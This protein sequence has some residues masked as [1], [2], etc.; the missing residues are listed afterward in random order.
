ML[1]FKLFTA[2]LIDFNKQ[3]QI[4]CKKT[5]T[6][7][8]KEM[9]NESNAE[10]LID[11]L[12]CKYFNEDD[13]RMPSTDQSIDHLQNFVF[14]FKK[15]KFNLKESLLDINKIRLLN[16]NNE[17]DLPKSRAFFI[18]NYPQIFHFQD[19]HR[20]LKCKQNQSSFSL[21]R[22]S[23]FERSSS[24]D[25][26]KSEQSFFNSSNQETS[27]DSS[28]IGSESA[29]EQNKSFDEME[30]SIQYIM[31]I[32]FWEL[33]D[34]ELSSF[35]LE[36]NGQKTTYETEKRTINEKMNFESLE[37]SQLPLDSNESGYF[38]L[39]DD[40]L[41]IHNSF[42]TSSS[43]Q[44]NNSPFSSENEQSLPIMEQLKQISA[45]IQCVQP[46]QQPCIDQQPKKLK[47]PIQKRPAQQLSILKP[48]QKQPQQLLQSFRNL[49]S[50]RQS[51]LLNSLNHHQANEL[52]ERLQSVEQQ[53][54]NTY[55]KHRTQRI[56]K[57]LQQHSQKKLQLEMLMQQSFE[58]GNSFKS[59][60]QPQMDSNQNDYNQI[61]SDS[62]NYQPIKLLKQNPTSQQL[63][64]LES[65]F[66]NDYVK[67]LP[68]LKYFQQMKKCR[69]QDS[70][71]I[72]DLLRQIGLK[73]SK[74][75]EE[76]HQLKSDQLVDQIQGSQLRTRIQNRIQNQFPH[77]NRMQ[78]EEQTHTQN[79]FDG[80][81]ILERKEK[82]LKR[83]KLKRERR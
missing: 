10:N 72:I 29:G 42:C 20:N 39:L 83:G 74:N 57:L 43:T 11:I 59:G 30:E 18:E 15:V 54:T 9:S 48:I 34:S 56:V 13:S 52:I 5:L 32:P 55:Q 69:D 63:K 71:T 31:Q 68:Q 66:Q 33:V 58:N 50:Q 12:E 41:S 38:D 73:R 60:E 24:L 47:K 17:I 36:S 77:Q 76:S 22:S 46:E 75:N 6:E 4:S 82:K 80:Q 67:A 8:V 44:I 14:A 35:L 65:I 26:C 61:S 25:S 81:V 51:R 40:Y 64:G 49:R 7:I 45:Q 79:Q 78:N 21:T 1:T 28:F 16:E 62:V 19:V 3:H 23:N 27:S 53:L 37:T 2:Q 70:K